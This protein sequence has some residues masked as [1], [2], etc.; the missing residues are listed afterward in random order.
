M[1]KCN[2]FYGVVSCVVDKTTFLQTLACR[3]LQMCCFVG[4]VCFVF[5]GEEKTK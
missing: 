2:G 5:A 4:R 3:G 1:I